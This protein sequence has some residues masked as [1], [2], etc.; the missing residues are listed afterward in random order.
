L[1]LR[2]ERARPGRRGRPARGSPGG[3]RTLGPRVGGVWPSPLCRRGLQSPRKQDLPSQLGPSAEARSRWGR[4]RPAIQRAF[5]QA[6]AQRTGPD[7]A[8]RSTHRALPRRGDTPKK[9]QPCVPGEISP[10][11][12]VRAQKRVARRT[13]LAW[14]GRRIRSSGLPP[15]GALGSGSR[16]GTPPTL[17]GRGAWGRGRPARARTC[18]VVSSASGRLSVPGLAAQARLA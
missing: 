5:L 14:K 8:R 16:T 13:G 17:Q 18:A 4:P 1:L 9:P 10:H 3:G 2:P 15:Q 12:L 6:L 11:D 7:L